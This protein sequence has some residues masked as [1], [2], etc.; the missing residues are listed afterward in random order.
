MKVIHLASDSFEKEIASGTVLVDF[1]AEWCGPCRMI[2]PVLD[3]LA[4]EIGDKGK[5]CKVNVDTEPELARK[6][7]VFSIPTLILF[8]DGEK[9]ETL[10]GVR[11]K[12]EL[13]QLFK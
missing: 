7:K 3:E 4:E 11:G 10:V 8:K 12:E 2:A 5:I 9:T 1:W 6:F 13:L